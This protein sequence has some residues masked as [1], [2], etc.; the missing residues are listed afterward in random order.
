VIGSFLTWLG[1]DHKVVT[2]VFQQEMINHPLR[3]VT[4]RLSLGLL[5]ERGL[6]A[7]AASAEAWPLFQSEL[8]LLLLEHPSSGVI[9]TPASFHHE[10]RL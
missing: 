7:G 1:D 9:L 8:A 4:A 6:W 2:E 3:M 5:L 10:L